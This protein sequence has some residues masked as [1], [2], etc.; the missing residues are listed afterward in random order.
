M[1][2]FT[3][4]NSKIQNP[5]PKQAPNSKFQTPNG[6]PVENRAALEFEI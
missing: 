3:T 1:Q 4:E 2:T 6:R 5:N